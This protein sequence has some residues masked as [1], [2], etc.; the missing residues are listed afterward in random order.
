MTSTK[1]SKL[2]FCSGA[3]VPAFA[4]DDAC[5]VPASVAAEAPLM[6]GPAVEEAPEWSALNRLASGTEEL[7]R[8]LACDL[9]GCV[10]DASLLGV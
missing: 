10:V 5:V 6:D 3:T 8:S 7:E 9:G 1:L 4:A 2:S